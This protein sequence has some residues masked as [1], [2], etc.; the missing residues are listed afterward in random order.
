MQ[1]RHRGNVRASAT[2]DAVNTRV[3]VFC[4]AGR[5]DPG[6]F[7]QGTVLE[8]LGCENDDSDDNDERR[9]IVRLDNGNEPETVVSGEF[10]MWGNNRPL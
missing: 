7:V 6:G 5:H 1:I 2:R 8:C 9:F 3:T 4:P 10:L